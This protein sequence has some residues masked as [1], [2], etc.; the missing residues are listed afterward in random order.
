MATNPGSTVDLSNAIL[1]LDDDQISGDAI[2]GGTIGAVT[3]NQLNLASGAESPATRSTVLG[4]LI[5]AASSTDQ[6]ASAAPYNTGTYIDLPPG[7]WNVF[8][9]LQT[10]QGYNSFLTHGAGSGGGA[11]AVGLST[12]N[13]TYTPIASQFHTESIVGGSIDGDHSSYDMIQG[14]RLID[15]SSGSTVR[16]Y[17]W[18]KSIVDSSGNFSASPSVWTKP[19]SD[20]WDLNSL[21]AVPVN[22]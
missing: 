15:Q 17:L 6:P 5:A 8:I 20:S 13:V 21:Y 11:I 4:Q 1:T 9:N 12:S 2:D 22:W 19:G 14:Q 3:I 18:V 16:L 10:D 7:K